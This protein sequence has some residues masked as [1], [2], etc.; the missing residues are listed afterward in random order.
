MT[1]QDI[2]TLYEFNYWAN[3]KLFTVLRTLM[4]EQFTKD[5]GSSHGG[6][7]GT[8]V[9]AMGAEEIWM[10]RWRG[11]ATT[12]LPK[13]EEFQN[14]DLLL[15]RWADI[16]KKVRSFCDGLKSDEDI[17]RSFD[18]KD[19][20]GNPH[21]SVLAHAMQ[22]LV[23][24]TTYHRGQIVTLLRQLGVKPVSTDMIAFYRE[25]SSQR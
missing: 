13:E 5:M 18:Y 21:T 4:P 7:R 3:N 1:L 10:K 9:H 15:L 8:L 20:K 19:L 6:I 2:R 16:E 14:I 23:N 25:Q 22:H 12:G 17:G 11:E 24:H